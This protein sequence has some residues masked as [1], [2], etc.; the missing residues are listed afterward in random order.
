MPCLQ[1]E[2]TCVPSVT[3]LPKV[4]EMTLV[5]G[6]S[7]EGDSPPWVDRG[8][9]EAVSAMSLLQE[10][11]CI[12]QCLDPVQALQQAAYQADNE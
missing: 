11:Y 12:G 5:G 4:Q 2:S 8:D 3:W 9:G 7:I 6:S 1:R 10:T